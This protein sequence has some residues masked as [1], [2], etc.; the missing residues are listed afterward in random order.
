MAQDNI[1]MENNN[2]DKPKARGRPKNTPDNT[3]P[4]NIKAIKTKTDKKEPKQDKPEMKEAVKAKADK[5][6]PKHDKP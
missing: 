2:M 3:Q 6:E 5:K 4:E 1:N